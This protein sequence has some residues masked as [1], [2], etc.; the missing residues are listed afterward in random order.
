MGK[1]FIVTDLDGTLLD[2]PNGLSDENKERLN[3]LIDSGLSL[4]VATG[5]DLKKA[6]KALKGLKIKYPVILNNGSLLGD[7]NTGEFWKITTIPDK[8]FSEIFELAE[9]MNL[10]PIVMIGYQPQTGKIR[11]EKGTWGKKGITY[12]S[13]AQISSFIEHQIV[14]LQY[15]ARIE[16]LNNLYEQIKHKFKDQ[17]KLV[18]IED[19]AYDQLGI[20]GHWYWLEINSSEAGKGNMMVEFAH[21]MNLKLED[22]VVFGDNTN[23]LE[24]MKLAGRSIAVKNACEEVKQLANEIT[25]SAENLGV[26]RYIEDHWDEIM[27][28]L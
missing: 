27:L 3:R 20:E 8:I 6:K 15:H 19:V 10:K 18:Y 25:E 21:R 17:V 16:H 14:S 5:R 9:N 13:R 26:V 24:L 11:T 23:D 4:S 1:K 7:L 2:L 28:N 12:L 22:F